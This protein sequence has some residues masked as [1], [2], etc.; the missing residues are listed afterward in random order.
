MQTVTTQ[1]SPNKKDIVQPVG[2]DQFGRE[3]RKYLPYVSSGN[4]GWYKE[5]QVDQ[6]TGNPVGEF[7]NFYANPGVGIPQDLHPYSQT[8]FEP[9]PLNRVLKQGAPG[10]AWQPNSDPNSLG[11]NTVKRRY[12]FNTADDVRLITYDAATHKISY[13]DTNNV[14]RFYGA[15]QLYAN[16]TLDEA[17][18]AVIEY[19]D[20]EGRT[21]LKRVETGEV[22]TPYAETYYIYDDFG[23]LITVLPPEA[24]KTLTQN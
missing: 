13:K 5:S 6:S 12:E 19:V 23:S 14:P 20:K 7:A 1:G 3:A 18:H 4:N 15:N 17:N 11:D 9:S 8:V 16:K 22:A 21:V 24:V 2:Y 10:Q